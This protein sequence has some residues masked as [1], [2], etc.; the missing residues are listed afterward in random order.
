M[1]KCSQRGR[2]PF[3]ATGEFTVDSYVFRRMAKNIGG[4]RSF[5]KVASRYEWERPD[6]RS[7]I[8]GTRNENEQATRAKNFEKRLLMAAVGGLFLVGP[9]WQMVLVNSWRYASLISTT[10][11]V[12]LFGFVM[13]WFLADHKDV[14]ASTAAYAA[15]L[16]VFVAASSP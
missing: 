11:F 14:L 15:V 4:G 6:D 8:C 3:L 13:A 10:V 5:K 9:M 12:S 7:A 1:T 16:V 2:D